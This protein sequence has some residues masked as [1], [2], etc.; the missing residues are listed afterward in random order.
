M[1]KLMTK[2]NILFALVSCIVLGFM[3]TQ[4]L[5]FGFCSNP[6]TFNSTT[7]CSDAL[8]PSIGNFGIIFSITL[9]ALLSILHFTKKQY[10]VHG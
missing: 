6:Y 4:P 8:L 5:L 1:N 10:T 9:L 2:R 7:R 3:L